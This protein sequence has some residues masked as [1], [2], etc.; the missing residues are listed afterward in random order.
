MNIEEIGDFDAVD[1]DD[2]GAAAFGLEAEPAVPRAG[3]E[4]ALAGEVGGDRILAP[5]PLGARR[6]G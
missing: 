5:T 4:N 3:V 1:G 2:F 6:G